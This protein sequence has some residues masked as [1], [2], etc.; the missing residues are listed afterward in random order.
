MLFEEAM[1]YY[2]WGISHDIAFTTFPELNEC[3]E[4]EVAFGQRNRIADPAVQLRALMVVRALL[5]EF[6][7]QVE[8]RLSELDAPIPM[9][10][11][12][13]WCSN[14]FLGS[15]SARALSTAVKGVEHVNSVESLI[16]YQ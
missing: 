4:H 9:I 6:V 13:D 10:V 8:D 15:S 14:I 7:D 1:M 5:P 2:S 16:P 11:G 3:A 12:Q